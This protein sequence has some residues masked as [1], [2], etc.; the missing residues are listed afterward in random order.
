MQKLKARQ[1][2]TKYLKNGIYKHTQEW[3]N[4]SEHDRKS[5]KVNKYYINVEGKRVFIGPPKSEQIWGRISGQDIYKGI[6]SWERSEMNYYL[7]DFYRPLVRKQL[8]PVDNYPLLIEFKM[9]TTIDSVWDPS[10]MWIYGKVFEDVLVEEG[11]IQ[12]DKN[13]CISY[14]PVA[15]LIIP[16]NDWDMRRLEFH[17]K[18]DK[19]KIAKQFK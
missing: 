9:Y 15:P 7:K 4:A 2:P 11:I 10:N 5:G 8:Q 3:E 1:F 17:I 16:V 12:D 6:P 13:D 18:K 19:R 14:P